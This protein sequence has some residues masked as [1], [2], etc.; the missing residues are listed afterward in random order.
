MWFNVF[1]T[2]VESKN[3]KQK[4]TTN[5]FNSLIKVKKEDVFN[6]FEYFVLEEKI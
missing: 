5:R 4:T 1:S 3:C 6:Q 2:I